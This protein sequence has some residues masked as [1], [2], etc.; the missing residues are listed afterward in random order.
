LKS[1]KISRGQQQSTNPSTDPERGICR[2]TQAA[3]REVSSQQALK[4]PH[5]VILEWKGS[6]KFAYVEIRALLKTEGT[7]AK[8]WKESH[9]LLA[10]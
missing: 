9:K 6:F 7:F 10:E 1:L 8:H 4:N 2:A 5:H 3:H